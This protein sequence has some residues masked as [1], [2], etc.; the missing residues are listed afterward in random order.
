MAAYPLGISTSWNAAG[1]DDGGEIIRQVGEL[2]FSCIEV[3]YRVSG[4]A[5]RGIADAVRAG[6]V[7]VLSVHNYTPLERGEKA[8]SRGGDKRNLA[9]PDEC[10]REKAVELTLRSL[11][12]AEEL[13]AKALVLHL[14]ETDMGKAYFGELAG[15]VEKEGVASRRAEELRNHIRDG[16]DAVKGRYL[17]AAIRSLQDLL[18]HAEK[19]GIVLGIENRYYFHQVPL[20]EEIPGILARIGSPFVRYWHDIGHAYVMRILGF[21]IA[22]GS[23]ARLPETAFGVHIHDAVFTGDHK[24]P[25]SGEIPLPSILG[26]IPAQ[27]I[28]IV[29]V[30]DTVARENIIRSV[31]F[32]EALGLPT[33]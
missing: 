27:A 7:R 23:S 33:G 1:N 3:E 6:R 21:D 25:G 5:A 32:L 14:G 29:E 8:T 15:I 28:R 10:E 17:D 18:P 2:G 22:E 20:P 11:R 9:S 4:E 26:R 24:A 12:L 30:S 13:G 19:T 16:R 31:P